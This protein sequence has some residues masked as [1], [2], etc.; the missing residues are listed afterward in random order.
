[1]SNELRGDINLANTDGMYPKDVTI[2]QPRFETRIVV[3]EALSESLFPA[4]PPPH[5]QK[6]ERRGQDKEKRKKNIVNDYHS[7]SSRIVSAISEAKRMLLIRLFE[8]CVIRQC[9]RA[10]KNV[11]RLVASPRS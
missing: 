5:F 11:V 10:R 4:A 1:M 9:V 2:G 6:I 3:R 7:I 8:F